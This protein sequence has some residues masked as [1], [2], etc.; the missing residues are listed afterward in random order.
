MDTKRALTA[1]RDTIADMVKR[2]GLTA[3]VKLLAQMT[4]SSN[5]YYQNASPCNLDDT[6]YS[7]AWDIAQAFLENVVGDIS[8]AMR[9]VE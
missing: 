9:R 6:C 8:Q 5:R 1:D 7:C 3:T 4:A 2:R